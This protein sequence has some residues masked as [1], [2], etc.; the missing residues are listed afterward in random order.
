MHYARRVAQPRAHSVRSA[1]FAQ[2]AG[3]TAQFSRYS[4]IV[5]VS[6][7]SLCCRF[8]LFQTF[9]VYSSLCRLNLSASALPE[10][11]CGC[12]YPT[13][14]V[15]ILKQQNQYKSLIYMKK[16]KAVL[17]VYFAANYSLRR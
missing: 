16:I 11:V 8:S 7:R 17:Y 3:L 10:T 1:A 13:I 6:L 9:P 4:N 12:P 14:K 15:L 2:V 5:W